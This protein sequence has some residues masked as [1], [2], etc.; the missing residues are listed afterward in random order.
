MERDRKKKRPWH[1][2]WRERERDVRD[3]V[4]EEDWETQWWEKLRWRCSESE[5]TKLKS[6]FK[7]G[8]VERPI[9]TQRRQREGDHDT[10]EREGERK[11][12][13]WVKVRLRN[14][15]KR[16]REKLF[17]RKSDMPNEILYISVQK[18]KE[19]EK[20]KKQK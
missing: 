20:Q 12:K 17:K 6:M 19:R 18:R 2:E 7:W 16:Q 15:W 1:V 3:A 9:A 4:G 11:I 10:H 13:T 8:E 14:P 5:R